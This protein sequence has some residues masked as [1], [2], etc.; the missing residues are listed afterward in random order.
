MSAFQIT[1]RR[2]MQ[3]ALPVFFFHGGGGT[4][5]PIIQI[6][7]IT[8][9]NTTFTGGAPTGTTVGSIVVQMAAGAPFTGT[10]SLTGT[11]AASFQIVGTTL[12][13]SGTVATGSYAINIVATMPGAIG[14][15]FTQPFTI[16]GSSSGNTQISSLTL[17][18]T[19]GSTQ[20][21]NFI[22]DIVGMSFAQGDVPAG[23]W[24]VIKEPGGT[25]Q[26]QSS[27]PAVNASYYPDGSLC[28]AACMF[29]ST[30]SIAGS[31]S[32][33]YQ[34]WNGGT[35]PAAGA[36]TLAEVYTE[37]L[38]I[39]GVGA[40]ANFGL[41]GNWNAYLKSDANN[42]AQYVY[43]DGA[44][45]TVW[46]VETEFA[47]TAGGTPHGQLFC[48]HYIAA[49]TD[50]LGA[51][52]G[53][54][55][56]ARICQPWYN[57]DSPVKNWRAFS[58]LSTQHGAGPTTIPLVWPATPQTFTSTAAS[59][60]LTAAVTGNVSHWYSGGAGGNLIPGYVTVAGGAADTAISTTRIYWAATRNATTTFQLCKSSNNVSSSYVTAAGD[61]TGVMTFNPVPTCLH[62]GT[63][64][65]H[66]VNAKWNFFQGAGS[67]T[68]DHTTRCQYNAPY[69]HST[70]L[71]PP[72]NQGLVGVTDNNATWAAS[73]DWNPVSIGPMNDDVGATGSSDNLG[74]T[75]AYTARHFFNQ[76]AGGEKAVRAIGLAGAFH[77]MLRQRATRQLLNLRN[78]SYTGMPAAAT[79]V[80]W[81]GV[82]AST[83]TAP[84][85]GNNVFEWV[86]STNSHKPSYAYYPTLVY[87]S[88]E[89]YDTLF[90]QANFSTSV[91]V[92]SNRNIT[93]P[94][95]KY[96]IIPINSGQGW[97]RTSSWGTR[98]RQHAAQFCRGAVHPDGSQIL[99]YILDGADD[100]LAVIGLCNTAAV[101]NAYYVSVGNFAVNDGAAGR[102]TMVN[103][104][105]FMAN[106]FDVVMCMSA[107]S[108]RQHAAAIAYVQDRANFLAYYLTTFGGYH[109]YTEYSHMTTAPRAYGSGYAAPIS[110]DAEFGVTAAGMFSTLTWTTGARAFTVT[111]LSS[112]LVIST[113]D[114]WIF[115][116]TAANAVPA[117][118]TADVP[119]YAVNVSGNSFDLS[120]SPG[121]SVITPTNTTGSGL[122]SSGRTGI[123]GLGGPWIIWATPPDAASGKCPVGTG[124]DNY[125]AW[126]NAAQNY[127]IAVGATGLTN[128]LAD[129]ATRLAVNGTSFLGF[130]NWGYQN[131]F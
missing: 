111:G 95:T 55:H 7:G 79:G 11:D 88:P 84:P 26:P 58:S 30:V 31:A 98:D 62:F 119:Y 126:S 103:G 15:P 39:S 82:N 9:S 18:N 60:N 114:K 110:S 38:Q 127:L 73:Y 3:S 1:R 102:M 45:G 36:R 65:T 71:I 90:E 17:V 115:D 120:A 100:D 122:P 87:G 94:V 59:K 29:R 70:G 57:V 99:Q 109:F 56:I 35:H 105:T 101:M 47:A 40:G 6:T 4:G 37:V 12:K 10:L 46:R 21:A 118:F 97:L 75:P 96:G 113:G 81:D 125:L 129:S 128:V 124:P 91:T 52:G 67:L 121:G 5:V 85:T 22:S 112:G 44:A 83:F 131:T 123:A 106:Y 78:Q 92:P 14:S 25:V 49:L 13:T 116:P 69:L 2:I 77:G 23:T 86:E 16:V 130:P 117:G 24:F 66:N 107:T 41:T 80:Y 63:I 42:L 72:W 20:A 104:F 28:W 51:L 89:F 68:A 54:R 32:V 43:L 108:N 76:S 33:V 50:S 53:F 74:L 27:T 34:I 19:S 64:Y 61:A 8:L 93:Y 48:Y